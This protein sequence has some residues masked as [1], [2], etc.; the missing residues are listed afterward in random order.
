MNPEY[1]KVAVEPINIW[2][3]NVMGQSI[4]VSE[5]K[6]IDKYIEE[7]FNDKDKYKEKID[8]LVNNYVYNLG[9]SAEVGANYIIE[10]IQNKINERRNNQ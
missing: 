3:R 8:D 6:N 5:C 10:A 2:S 1:E 4:P 9:N 7:M